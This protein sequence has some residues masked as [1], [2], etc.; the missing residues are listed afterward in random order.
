VGAGSAGAVIASRVSED[1]HH[2]VLL[3]EAGPD[4]PHRL[5]ADLE[6]GGRNSLRAHDWGFKHR[7][8]NQQP[9]RFPMPRGRV[10]GGSSAVNTCI[11]LRGQPYDYDEWAARGLPDWSWAKCEPAFRRLE[12]DLDFDDAHHGTDGP[13]P[14][15]RHQ[16][17][18][19]VPWQA[20]FLEACEELGYPSVADHN[21]PLQ[22]GA[23]ATPMNKISGRRISAAEAYLTADVR[24]RPNLILRPHTLVRCI[25]FQGV[26]AIGVEVE[27][28]DQVERY[29]GER[30]VLAA[31][32]L[33]TPALLMRSG[34]G[35]PKDLD[36]LNVP[37]IADVPGVGHRLL[38]HPGCAIFLRVRRGFVRNAPLI[39]TM[40]RYRSDA[41]PDCNMTIQPGSMVPLPGVEQLALCSIMAAVGKPRGHG[42]IVVTSTDA[43][44]K[45]TIDSRLLDHD[46][47]RRDAVDAMQRAFELS[48]T[49][50]LRAM[51]T[52]FWPSARVLRHPQRTDRWI[53]WATDSGYHP[54]GTVP[55]GAESDPWAACDGRGRVRGIRGLY[56]ADASLM[57]TIPTANTNLPTL[58]IGERFGQWLRDGQL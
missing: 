3:I 48:Q 40:L 22:T 52:P 16:N 11:A 15:R 55:M 5:P 56:V 43:R 42:R 10:V 27:V 26:Q 14:I 37:R 58:M 57:P 41:G 25:L 7:V 21:A 31:G 54:S 29:Y 24:R 9:V 51:A 38:D 8:N 12:T 19:L 18:E 1:S 28:N 6:N 49:R 17:Q 23:A 33:C 36:R 39:Q 44:A 30:I 20:G 34:V 46:A 45:P 35:P 32:A 53:R 50:A 47:D 4:Y 2:R 13:L